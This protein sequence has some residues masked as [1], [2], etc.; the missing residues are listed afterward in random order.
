MG[1]PDLTEVRT[2]EI[3]DAFERCVARYGLAGSSLER[4]AEEAGMKRSILRHYIGNR[5]DLIHALVDRVVSKYRGYLQTFVDSI[6]EDR[7]VEQLLKFFFPDEPLETTDGILVVE[8]LIAAGDEYPR[9]RQIMAEYIDDLVSITAQQ[10]RLEYPSATRQQCW[11]VAYGV[12]SICFNQ[13]SL[14][15]LGLP[16]KYLSAARSCSRGLIESLAH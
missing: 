7:R 1:R 4:V 2:T 15:P 3:L 16:R 12:V 10:L 11:N 5:D 8:A 13:D 6:S 14:S 9:V